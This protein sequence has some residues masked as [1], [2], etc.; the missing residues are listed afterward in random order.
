M[1]MS[2][3][4]VGYL[5]LQPHHLPPGPRNIAA[6]EPGCRGPNRPTRTATTNRTQS[7]TIRRMQHCHPPA[8]LADIS[9]TIG[10]PTAETSRIWPCTGLVMMAAGDWG[11]RWCPTA[12]ANEARGRTWDRCCL[13]N[14]NQWEQWASAMATSSARMGL[15]QAWQT[16][17]ATS[18]Q[19]STNQARGPV[20]P[21]IILSPGGDNACK[22]HPYDAFRHLDL[23]DWVLHPN[24]D[25]PCYTDLRYIDSALLILLIMYIV[26]PLSLMLG[27]L[28]HTIYLH[29]IIYLYVSSPLPLLT[30]DGIGWG[31][32]YQYPHT[33]TFIMRSRYTTLLSVWQSELHA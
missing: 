11:M 12:P 33:F 13:P 15:H 18:H 27:Y 21:H 30:V 10:S 22:S 24:F 26:T 2:P 1:G 17:Q 19:P 29:D 9:E 3:E 6:A 5:P 4:P 23:L 31:E 25:T 7:Q 16:G 28:E 20:Q 14:H 8:N 32:I